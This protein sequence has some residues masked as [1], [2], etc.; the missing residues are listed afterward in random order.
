[1]IK[2]QRTKAA[3]QCCISA[4]E[5]A[6]QRHISASYQ[7]Y[8]SAIE[9]AYERHISSAYQCFI[10][11]IE[12]TYQRCISARSFR[13]LSGQIHLGK[14]FKRRTFMVDICKCSYIINAI[15]E[16]RLLGFFS[17]Y[18]FSP[19]ICVFDVHAYLST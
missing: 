16:Y 15:K 3:Y 8:L 7:C 4:I 19:G 18:R 13:S 10:S 9:D 11:T 5:V 1:V 14:I 6:Y 2:R 12:A 17:L